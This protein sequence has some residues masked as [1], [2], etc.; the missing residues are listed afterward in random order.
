MPSHNG[1]LINGGQQRHG[2]HNHRKPQE[3]EFAFN[4]QR[5]NVGAVFSHGG[6]RL[7]G[8]VG[9]I[10][11]VVADQQQAVNQQPFRKQVQRPGERHSAQHT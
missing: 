11:G 5:L 9:L 4:T 7:L 2:G 3:I 6:G 8:V 1:F 10:Q